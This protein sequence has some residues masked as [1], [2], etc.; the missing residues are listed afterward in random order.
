[1][2]EMRLPV[3]PAPSP[4]HYPLEINTALISLLPSNHATAAS[5]AQGFSLGTT[6]ALHNSQAPA[7][8]GSIKPA[9]YYLL[10][11]SKLL[12]MNKAQPTKGLFV[13]VVSAFQI[14]QAPASGW[15]TAGFF[16]QC[17]ELKR[18][19]ASQHSLKTGLTWQF[20]SCFSNNYPRI[21]S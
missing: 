10:A 3:L 13:V 17:L 18:R 7:L 2:V 14:L 11:P 5:V 16:A 1:V 8:Q 15:N 12:S 19:G 9:A 20:N 21:Y 4:A 6:P